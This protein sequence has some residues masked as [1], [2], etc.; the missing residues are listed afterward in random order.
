MLAGYRWVFSQMQVLNQRE[1]ES[2]A[3]LLLAC[4][5]TYLI[6]GLV[7]KPDDMSSSRDMANDFGITSRARRFG[8]ASIP[9]DRLSPD[10]VRVEGL[11]EFKR[12]AI[13]DHTAKKNPAGARMK[14]SHAPK[15]HSSGLAGNEEPRFQCGHL[16]NPD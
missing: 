6:H 13:L 9:P 11:L 5:L 4:I 15:V 3:V 1:R 12:Y 16:H 10:F 7:K 2:E 14:T 8:I